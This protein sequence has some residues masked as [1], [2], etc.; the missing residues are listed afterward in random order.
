MADY[1]GDNLRR[2]MAKLGLTI[3]QVVAKS[4]LDKRTIQGILGGSHKSHMRSITRLAQGLGVSTDEFFLDPSQLLYRQFD[5][6]TNPVVQEVIGS[7]P[8]LFTGWTAAH[9][10]ELHSRFGDGGA[11]TFDGALAAVRHMNENREAFGQLAVLLESHRAKLIRGLLDVYFRETV[12][13]GELDEPRPTYPGKP[14]RPPGG[15]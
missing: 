2:L 10:A 14:P 7:H 8:E 3:E 4:G 1:I 13:S 12:L 9:F 6:R 5:Q 11:L 15:A